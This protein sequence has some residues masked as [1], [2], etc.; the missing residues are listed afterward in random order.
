MAKAYDRVSWSYLIKAK[1]YFHS[2]RGVKQGDPLS[3]A[4]FILSVEVLSRALNL[5][6]DNAEYV[7]Y[8]DTIIF[9]SAE[10]ESLKRIMK[11]LQ[12]YE[13]ISGHL[14]NKGK[15]A[16]YMH[17]KIS[18]ALCQQVEQ[19][20]GFKRDQFPLK[21]LG[22]PIF[23]SRRKKVYYNDLIK[24]VKNK[25]QNW[26]GKLLS[27]GGKAVLINSVLQTFMWN[28][29]CKKKKPT[30]VQ[31]KDGSQVWKRM[32]ETRDQVD[33]QI[34]WDPINGVC[35]VW[36]DN[37]TKLGSLKQVIPP[38]FQIDTSIEEVSH[39]M[40]AEG[41]DV[42]K[43]H[44]KLPRKRLKHQLTF[45]NCGSK[46]FHSKYHSSFGD[47]GS[48]KY[49]WKIRNLANYNA[50]VGIIGLR[51]QIY[52]TIVQWWYMQGPT[53]LK[54]VMQAAPA[55]ICWQLWKRRNTIMHGDKMNKIKV[56]N[57]INYRASR[58]NPGLSSASFCI[59]DEVGNL[60]YAESIAI[61]DG[62]EF[63]IKNDLV[64]VM[65]ESDSLSMINIIQGIWEIP[66]KISME[67]NKINF[68]RNKGQ[69]QFA[70]ILREGTV[71]FHSFV[72]LPT[73]LKKILNT[74]KMMMPNFRSKIYRN[75]EPD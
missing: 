15:S 10:G 65:I 75:R 66:W 37:W 17:H 38:N 36:E 73:G 1:G 13:A 3:P 31:W 16:F 62:I 22:C 43:L 6:F 8:D 47:C 11:I 42:Q 71:H 9:A 49:Q 51:I 69:V 44:S 12:D 21:Y 30:E 60:I 26:Q 33:Q 2:T 40:I 19:I 64:P 35:D 50:D 54:S 67:V 14:I 74:D 72:D 32:I 46:E 57:G 63:C 45:Q 48:S 68:W 4:L 56:I 7:G 28:K 55:F 29:Y 58:G 25:L 53:K 41:W 59:R 23:H 18:G 39:F 5:E 27:L 20:T 52:Q 70:H 24:K 61:L 34:W